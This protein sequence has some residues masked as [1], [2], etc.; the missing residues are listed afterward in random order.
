MS[1][2]TVCGNG[3]EN[4]DRNRIKG[5]RC[6]AC[7]TRRV[8]L[9]S[10]LFAQPEDQPGPAKKRST[11]E[12]LILIAEEAEACIQ[13]MGPHGELVRNVQLDVYRR[14]SVLARTAVSDL[15]TQEAA[16]RIS[17]VPGPFR[18]SVRAIAAKADALPEPQQ[19][20]RI[21]AQGSGFVDAPC[22]CRELSAGP[23]GGPYGNGHCAYCPWG[24][25]NP[26]QPD[27]GTSTVD[28][29]DIETR[30]HFAEHESDCQIEVPGVRTCSCIVSD[31]ADM[32]RRLRSMEKG[33][34][35]HE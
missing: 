35:D 27:P 25:A 29:D 2:C 6:E 13:V 14:V 20:V 12:A 21:T 23:N 24:K 16:P 26:I 5:E 19:S 7:G 33:E 31:A 11:R 28:L 15:S 8:S 3:T 18:D 34:R 1:Y 9:A 32:L 17:L 22:T 4:F 30:I 10:Q